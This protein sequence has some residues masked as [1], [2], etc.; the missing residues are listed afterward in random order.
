VRKKLWITY[1]WVDNDKEDVDYVVQELEKAGLDVKIDKYQ[2]RAGHRLWEQIDKHISNP[3]ESDGWA[4]YIT[5]NSLKREAC[6]EELAYALDR[7]LESREN[8][9]PII[10]IFPESLG[11][12]TIIPGAIKTRLYVSLKDKN[13]LERIV[14]A[15]EGREIR[16]ERN[17]ILPFY[18]KIHSVANKN[19]IEVGPRTGSW[20]PFVFGYPNYES[21]DLIITIALAKRGDVS[22]FER[23]IITSRL[24]DVQHGDFDGFY[25]RRSSTMVDPTTSYFIWVNDLP[26]EI[27]FGDINVG[28]YKLNSNQLAYYYP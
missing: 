3:N 6:R 28:P 26:S 11:I 25:F 22:M 13:W 17:E 19:I 21:E 18:L 8:D 2:I 9:Y 4:I 24:G 1:A 27:L 14:A 12:D 16:I 5:Q 15:V 20:S 10:G 23:G 7:A